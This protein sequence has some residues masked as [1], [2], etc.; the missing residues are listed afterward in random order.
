VLLRL[1]SGE[2][3]GDAEEPGEGGALNV[4]AE[5]EPGG[6]DA[7]AAGALSGDQMR[8]AVEA[9]PVSAVIRLAAAI[10]P[11]R[12]AA[13]L[14][15]LGGA[16]AVLIDADGAR[17]ASPPPTEVRSTV[18]AGDSSLAGYLLAD[19]AGADADERLQGA[20][21]YGSA[22]AALP[23]TQLATPDDLAASDIPV[24]PIGR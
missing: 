18:G 11:S 23:G 5:E 6:A 12:V 21:R 10:V 24:H 22:T 1:R 15:T 7:L 19:L 17:Q 3:A 20:V 9:D 14:I 2:G 8:A 13:A 16:G 4:P